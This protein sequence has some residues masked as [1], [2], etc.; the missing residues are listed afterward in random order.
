MI[1]N[2]QLNIIHCL[3]KLNFTIKKINLKVLEQFIL[4][5]KV[6]MEL[7]AETSMTKYLS[8]TIMESTID[9]QVMCKMQ[10]FPEKMVNHH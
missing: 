1:E 7:P 5:T 3:S 6:N 9:T 8:F 10:N 2:A 4:K